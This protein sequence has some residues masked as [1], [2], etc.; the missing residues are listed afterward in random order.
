MR[1]ARIL[2]NIAR[3]FFICTSLTLIGIIALWALA[4]QQIER[5][6]AYLLGQYQQY[7]EQQYYQAVEGLQ[8]DPASAIPRMEAF[9]LELA[10]V[11]NGDR[12]GQMKK[13]L[14]AQLVQSYQ[15]RGDYV[16][17]L[18]WA[19]QWLQFDP[20]DFDAMLAEVDALLANPEQKA[21]GRAKLQTLVTRYFDIPKIVRRAAALGLR[22]AT[23]DSSAPSPSAGE[24]P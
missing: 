22:P 6:E 15:R 20:R 1:S 7:Y 13:I 14:L 12:L 17:A 23:F 10:E 5:L 9:S 21:A 4:P 24:S 8:T 16:Q 19:Q 11:K 3:S 2:A 18:F